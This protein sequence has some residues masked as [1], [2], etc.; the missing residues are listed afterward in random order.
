MAPRSMS[1]RVTPTLELSRIVVELGRF[2]EPPVV[3]LEGRVLARD[4]RV[5]HASEGVIVTRHL[6]QQGEAWINSMR[7]AFQAQ[8]DGGGDR[9]GAKAAG[10]A[11]GQMKED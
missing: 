5:T 3:R 9:G 11:G 7:D 8:F 2:G 6:G 1:A 10:R 4:P